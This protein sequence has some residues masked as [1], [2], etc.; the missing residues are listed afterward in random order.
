MAQ[1][2]RVVR[3]WRPVPAVVRTA[4]GRRV[5][6]AVVAG[7]LV[8]SCTTGGG[9]RGVADDHL[10]RLPAESA[11]REAVLR[12]AGADEVR[13]TVLARPSLFAERSKDELRL[14][15]G[16]GDVL[17]TDVCLFQRQEGGADGSVRVS[18]QWATPVTGTVAG[19]PLRDPR[20]YAVNGLPAEAG[21]GGAK[22][23]FSCV[24]PDDLR[25]TSRKAQLVGRVTLTG[26]PRKG[27]REDRDVRQVALAYLMAQRAVDAL[28]CENEPLRGEPVVKPGT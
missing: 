19:Q 22:V 17:P 7:L 4:R 26:G 3:P 14:W 12:A 16:T 10:C 23:G 21:E 9:E 20:R 18:F 11:E 8:A 13:T 15:R 5:L 6:V 25:D 2:R 27:P 24:M 1:S 28:G